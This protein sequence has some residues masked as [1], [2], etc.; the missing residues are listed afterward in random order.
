MDRPRICIIVPCWKR[1]AGTRRIINNILNQTINNWEAFVI[2]DGCPVFNT[3]FD[4][5]EAEFY[6]K[7]A[8]RDGNKLHLFNLDKNY[9]GY[10]YHILNYGIQNTLAKYIVIGNNDDMIMPFHFENY[11]SEIENTDYDLV[12]YKTFCAFN[13]TYDL[14]LRKT[15]FEKGG[16]GN[17][18]IIM[19]TETARKY[20]YTQEYGHDWEFIKNF[21]S[22][23]KVKLGESKCLS[24][25]IMHSAVHPNYNTN[26]D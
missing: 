25:V 16:V 10:G 23:E 1:P 2:G 12:A 15:C 21:V 7:V 8:Q 19:K 5:R 4:S 11:L 20:Q 13:N 24:Y 9:G 3:L 6:Q 17:A 14:S 26:I 22:N 18:E